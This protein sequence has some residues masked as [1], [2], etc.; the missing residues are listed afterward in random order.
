MLTIPAASLAEIPYLEGRLALADHVDEKVVRGGPSVPRFVEA[1]LDYQPLWLRA[2]FAMRWVLAKV[3]RLHHGSDQVARGV[4][5][6]VGGKGAFF[7][8]RAADASTHWVGRADDGHLSADLAVVAEPMT[9]GTR[10]FHVVTVV[11]HHD[12]RGPFYFKL[13][14]PF[15][16]LVVG[17]M[18]RAAAKRTRPQ[19]S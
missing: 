17:A 4:S 19:A 7:T 15:H 2:L 13:I 5:F 8:V 18:A 6:A 1:L 16:H 11:E 10:R 9:D 12:A 3:L 14:E